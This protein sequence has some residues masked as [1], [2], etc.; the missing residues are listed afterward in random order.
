LRWG[1]RTIVMHHRKDDLGFVTVS[2]NVSPVSTDGARVARGAAPAA[3]LSLA[4]RAVV[5][6]VGTGLL[7]AAVVGSG[8]MGERLAG[9]NVGLALLANTAA[10][11]AALVALIVALGP[12][13]GAHFNP[14]VTVADWVGGDLSWGDVRAYIAAQ[15]AGGFLGTAVANLMFETPVFSLSRHARTGPA[16]LFSEV[17]ATFGLV[18][19]IGTCAR[20]RPNAVP[21]AVASYISS[22][23]WF[24]ASTSFANPA[25]TLARA[26]SDSF[27]GIRPV[28]VPGFLV[29]QAI[30]GALAVGV[31]RW[32]LPPDP[33]AS[34]VR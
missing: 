33:D 4:R 10:T 12:L 34:D 6:A 17:V 28:D 20:R 5:E 13:S 27:A 15:V 32:L 18:L 23:Y 26:V 29:A 14:V 16:Q 2:G 21:L 30:G 11:G 24:T 9:G 8:I 22:A 25:V 19:I 31:V 7:V 1:H 3:R